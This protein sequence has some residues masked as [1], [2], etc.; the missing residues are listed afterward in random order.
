[1]LLKIQNKMEN[2][3]QIGIKKILFITV[4]LI[5]TEGISQTISETFDESNTFTVPSGVTS[6]TVEAWGG[7]GRGGT[8]TSNG[9]GGGGGGG[10][11]ARKVVT[12]TPNSTYTVNVGT[13]SSSTSAGGDS[14]FINSTTILAKGG[15]SV[16]N[17][18]TSGATG[19]QANSCI[20]DIRRSGGNGA[21]A[22]SSI[23]YRGGGG[24]S[25]AGI[26]AAGN[27]TTNSTGASAPT[28]GGD[29]GSGRTVSQ[30]NG[31][32]GLTP[33]GGG[34][35][36]YRT[37]GTRS[38]GN[39]ANGQ[40]IITYDI[41]TPTNGPGGV[42]SKL[43]LWLRSDLLDG[44]T[45]VSNNSNVTTWK[46]L[47]RGS[48]AT[49]PANV[50]S[51]KYRNN[52]TQNINFNAVVDFTNNQN[53]PTEVYTDNNSSKQ[54][55]KGT[56]G[57]YSQDFYVV[58]MP[59]IPMNH[60]S[61]TM[62]IFCGERS[63]SQEA[64]VTGV[65]MG[66]YSS[67]FN[68]EVL[69][70]CIGTNARY[71]MAQVN[72]SVTYSNVG[73]INA[74]TNASNNG[75]D[76]S[77]NGINVGNN[78]VNTNTFENVSDSRYWI[79][80]SK[81][82]DGSLD[83][84]VGEIITLDSRAT[85]V[86]RTKI[87][88]YLGIKYGITLGVNGTSQNYTNSD[89]A[90][91]WN[92]S[93]SNGFNYDI[94]GIG[95]D[96]I[97]ILNQ[98]QSKSVNSGTVLTIG[99]GDIAATNTAN[100]NEFPTDKSY[101]VWGSNG[102]NMNNSGTQLAVDLG[103][104]TIT[105]LTDI[106]NRKWK[107]VE[108]GGDVPTVRVSIPTASFTNG[109]P[110]LGPTDAY[111][112]VV[113]TNATFTAGV[114]TVFM[115]TSGTNQTC[116]YDFDGTKYITF[117]VAHRTEQPLHLTLDGFDDHIR[118]DKVN[119]I[120]N[121]FSI[122]TWIK[123]DGNNSLNSERT[124]VAKRN[125]SEGYRLTIQNDNKIK[126]EWTNAGNTY[127]AVSQT[128]IPNGKW[129]NITVTFSGTSLR[130]YID[131]LQD[132]SL[133]S[134]LA[135]P[136]SSDSYF[137]IG[138]EYRDKTT[139]LNLFKGNIDELRIWNQ[140]ISVAQIRFMMNQEI[141]RY[142]TNN[143][144]GKIIPFSVTKNDISS[145]QWSRLIA[146]YSMNSY[147]GTHLDD[148]SQNANRGSLVVPDK[149]TIHN[150]TAPLPY[151]SANNGEWASES[152]WLNGSNLNLPNDLSITNGTT[153]INWNIVRTSHNVNSTGN[154]TLL[155]L[156]V[157]NN[158]LSANN[159]SKVEIS[160]YLKLDGKIDLEGR[161]QLIQTSNSDLDP[162][163]SGS[164]ERDQQGTTNKFNYNYW[165]SPVSSINNST[166]N[167]GYTVSGVMKDGTNPA[168]PINLNW[169][170]GINPP[171]T[172]NPITLS[173]YWIFKFQNLTPDYANWSG[174][175]QNGLLSAG[176]G[177]TMKGSN[178]TTEKQ[179]YVFVGKPNNGQIMSTIAPNNL[180]L[181]GNP[182][183]S[184]LDANTFINDNV[185]STT[186]ALYFWEHFDTNNTHNL[187][188]YQG[189]YAVRNLTGGTT[190]VSPAEISGLGSSNRKPNRYIPVGQGFMI[191][192]SNTGGDVVFNNNQRA[193]H[194]EN[195]SN[196]NIMFRATNETLSVSH[197]DNNEED[198]V[199]SD[200][201]T[202]IHLGFNSFNNFHRQ[203]LI[204][205]MNELATESFDP[206]YDAPHL[207]NQQNDM[208]FVL[209][210]YKLTIQGEGYFD[211]DRTFPLG[212][213]TYA[214]GNIQFTIDEVE[215]LDD[216]IEIFIYDSEDDTYNSIRENIYE[217][218][219]PQGEFNNR[220]YLTFRSQDA[221]NTTDVNMHDGIVVTFT[222]QNQILNIQNNLTDTTVENVSLYNLL[223]QLITRWNVADE[224]Q[225][226]IQL[227]VIGVSTGPY[228]V[229]VQT[230][231]GT[232][233]KKIIIK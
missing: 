73:I 62:D 196:S 138:G 104:V 221:L 53:N 142:N 72:N 32:N 76:L 135:P 159:D 103:P 117:G 181:S 94:A 22:G 54:Y 172:T 133:I 161:S 215:N 107:V 12:V 60:A 174:A 43:Q 77:Y 15:S 7:G 74:R 92:S 41:P 95:R 145:L 126:M 35:G 183:P 118:V 229:Q 9:S 13:G 189:G 139:I 57:F 55:L 16:A 168:N 233:S 223:G 201:Y 48:D 165:S 59:D 157:N 225:L 148:D 213:K 79:G 46:T 69:A 27:N 144:T 149:I 173:S 158:T 105:T 228:I 113:A 146:Y 17:N 8:R 23:L 209:G 156:L 75:A 36:A 141:E 18:S 29:G 219:M 33:G 63:S 106:V 84:R 56:S 180:N 58:L 198:E 26:D 227:P 42:T 191:Y 101:L 214:E 167:H 212:V 179:N 86:E 102:Q 99:L 3:I 120:G 129:H 71:G 222:N 190:P 170:T 115:S 210:N 202:R 90:V 85:N 182:Y 208:Y 199:T 154:K 185:G 112:M 207:D 78:Q 193:F 203:I 68:N 31:S 197:F 119:N 160:H 97:S 218:Y 96:D 226:Q 166:I 111:V 39:G 1:M 93:N 204:G 51:P 205:F 127:T 52:A 230:N 155:G 176:Q 49:K 5:F 44:T 152:T 184:A 151:V 194:K 45:S 163:S 108:T 175:G 187:A 10:A 114:E 137:T 140:S 169:V 14:W 110:A 109:L 188:G 61:L 143:I 124:I 153:P 2:K 123:L 150:Q 186:G 19:G 136:T 195:S 81:G 25:S 220:F 147:I 38:G 50:G 121:A 67:R 6:V 116:T 211:V 192:G 217:V 91:I 37:S 64:D 231:T 162:T 65:G 89:A 128:A 21:N 177:Y 132:G 130:F 40:V 83:G 232:I 70:Y 28:G 98:K 206:G 66:N 200:G 134:M 80:R 216:D 178:Q 100:S 122:M 125:A 88:S 171:S 11:Y 24:G 87:Q 224:N 164:I 20:G 82:W 47:G 30:G 131:G 4:L 34:G